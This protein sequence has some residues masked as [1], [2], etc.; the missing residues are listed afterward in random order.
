VLH[1]SPRVCG[2]PGISACLS[3][4]T[5]AEEGCGLRFSSPPSTPGLSHRG[6]TEERALASKGPVERRVPL[7]S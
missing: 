4:S 6:E 2:L 3:A 5:G 7:T 1:F